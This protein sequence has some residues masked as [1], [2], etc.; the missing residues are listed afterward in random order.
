MRSEALAH[1]Q[2]CR[3]YV[4]QIV[5]STRDFFKH[6]LYIL[7]HSIG[8]RRIIGLNTTHTVQP[9][10]RTGMVFALSTDRAATSGHLIEIET[11]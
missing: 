8:L 9:F 2:M 3:R 6:T 11:V 5:V 10:K 1:V 4:N 7:C